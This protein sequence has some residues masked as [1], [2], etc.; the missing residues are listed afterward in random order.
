MAITGRTLD[1][2]SSEIQV[3]DAS[4]HAHDVQSTSCLYCSAVPHGDCCRVTGRVTGYRGYGPE[5]TISTHHGTSGTRDPGTQVRRAWKA[6][7][8]VLDPSAIQ[9]PRQASIRHRVPR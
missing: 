5:G 7:I 4:Q 3:N 9:T 1:Q 8:G 2:T 6:L